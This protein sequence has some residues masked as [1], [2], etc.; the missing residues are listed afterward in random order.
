MY[1]RC[2]LITNQSEHSKSNA[3]SVPTI[4]IILAC[5]R[6]SSFLYSPR[7]VTSKSLQPVSC[8]NENNIYWQ[9]AEIRLLYH[10]GA[11]YLK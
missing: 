10:L 5:R 11:I 4:L 2:N 6:L 8:S 3:S 1:F 9:S 7:K